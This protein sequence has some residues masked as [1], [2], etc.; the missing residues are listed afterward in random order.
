MTLGHKRLSIID[1]SDQASQPM[2]FQGTKLWVTYNGEIYNY[3]ELREKFK[4][5]FNRVFGKN[6]YINKISRYIQ[7]N[8]VSA[9]FHKIQ[10]GKLHHLLLTLAKIIGFWNC[11]VNILFAF[12]A[13]VIFPP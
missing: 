7:G 2:L 8:P 1:L 4:K 9:A 13:P 6:N 10:K 11:W 12:V 3:V 5:S